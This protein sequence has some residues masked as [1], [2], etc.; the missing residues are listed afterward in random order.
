M[1]HFKLMYDVLTDSKNRMSARDFSK[2]MSRYNV[3]P[4]RKRIGSTKT[5]SAPR[6]I[7]ISWYLPDDQKDVLIEQH[8]DN[9][10]KTAL[11]N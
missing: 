5:T 7:I 4:G 8:F 10:D 11:I 9:K 1:Q 6:G 2:S 3:K